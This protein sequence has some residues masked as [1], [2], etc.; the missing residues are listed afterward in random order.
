[1]NDIENLLNLPEYIQIVIATGYIGHSIARSGLRD[2]ERK[3]ELLYGIIV[4]GLFGYVAFDLVKPFFSYF[5]IPAII[6]VVSVVVISCLWRKV[7]KP[8]TNTIFQN[9]GVLNEDGIPNVWTGITQ[10]THA[11]PTQ[12]KV[13]LKDGSALICN[14][15]QSF[16]DAAFP[17]YYTDNDG[18]IALYVTSIRKTDGT[19]KEMTTVRDA[20]WG[21][22]LTYVPASE[23]SRVMIRFKKKR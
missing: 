19:T 6:A 5:L 2:K 18:N 4:F 12:V 21:D 14:N 7:G 3:D 1:M 17:K 16:G 23:I 13:L 9:A 11:G 22:R 8:L 15:V 20:D 10:C